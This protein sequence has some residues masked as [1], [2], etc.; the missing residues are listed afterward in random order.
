[1]IHLLQRFA[2]LG[3]VL[4]FLPVF[5]GGKSLFQ[6][7]RLGHSLTRCQRQTDF[8]GAAGL[9]RRHCPGGR[10]DQPEPVG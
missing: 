3:K 5:G 6:P 9:R 1:M 10:G 2:K 8:P 4:P 7:V